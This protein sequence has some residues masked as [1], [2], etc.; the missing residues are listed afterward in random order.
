MAGATAAAGG[1]GRHCDSGGGGRGRGFG[2]RSDRVP[3]KHDGVFIAKAKEDALCTK[4]CC[5][6]LSAPRSLLISLA[7]SHGFT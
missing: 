4:N 7:V 5:F 2:G 1:F 3:H 6:N